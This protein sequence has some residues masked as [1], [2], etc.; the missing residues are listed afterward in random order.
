MAKQCR[1][2]GTAMGF[3]EGSSMGL[4]SSCQTIE[5]RKAYEKHEAE[6][7]EATKVQTAEAE[8]QQNKREQNKEA[9]QTVLLTTE[10]APNLNIT[11]RISIITSQAAFE[12]NNFKDAFVGLMNPVKGRSN[13]MEKQIDELKDRALYDLQRK[14]YEASANGVVAVDLDISTV[15]VG[16]ISMLM[17]V[18][19]GTAVI[20]ED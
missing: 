11:K 1:S 9:I 18:A 10:T 3:L 13:E 7:K 5:N 15:T 20:I 14:A 16:S 6:L 2:C 8:T 12:I 4:C 19:S 17:L